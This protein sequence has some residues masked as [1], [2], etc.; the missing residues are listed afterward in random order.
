MKKSLD[1][2]FKEFMDTEDLIYTRESVRF[3]KDLANRN[4]MDKEI[5]KKCNQQIKYFITGEIDESNR[6]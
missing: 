5:V 4:L 1:L 6:D 2:K 3:F